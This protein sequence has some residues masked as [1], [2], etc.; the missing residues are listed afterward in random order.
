MTRPEHNQ[1]VEKKIQ[2]LREVYRDAPEI[3]KVAL[4]R[5]LPLLKSLRVDL[6]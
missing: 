5:A 1:I 4:E 2:Q 6:P 3:A